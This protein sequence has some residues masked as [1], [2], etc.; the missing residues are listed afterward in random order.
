MK[1]VYFL[2]REFGGGRLAGVGRGEEWGR[3]G[4]L[5]FAKFAWEKIKIIKITPAGT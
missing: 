4:H 5:L 2:D 3:R 1:N